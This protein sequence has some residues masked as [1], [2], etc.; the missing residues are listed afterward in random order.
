MAEPEFMASSGPAG[1]VDVSRTN[2][3][4]GDAYAT[5]ELTLAQERREGES[6]TVPNMFKIPNKEG[7]WVTSW[8]RSAQTE[9]HLVLGLGSSDG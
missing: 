2:W 8:E 9:E 1:S 6:P 7:M 4:W 5:Q 3:T